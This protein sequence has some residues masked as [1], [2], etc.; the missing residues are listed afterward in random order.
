MWRQGGEGKSRESEVW[1][2]KGWD[3]GARRHQACF[4]CNSLA[5]PKPKIILFFFAKFMGCALAKGALQGKAHESIPMLLQPPDPNTALLQGSRGTGIP[6]PP[7]PDDDNEAV[8]K[9]SLAASSE[10]TPPCDA[11]RL[12]KNTQG[13][14]KKEELR[15]KSPL[16]PIVRVFCATSHISFRVV[17]EN[18]RQ[19]SSTPALTGAQPLGFVLF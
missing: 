19:I 11:S 6:K 18:Y 12:P 14:G 10:E 9:T 17:L 1:A 4:A 3:G 8:P 13:E 7:S 5:E 2:E 16:H 15:R